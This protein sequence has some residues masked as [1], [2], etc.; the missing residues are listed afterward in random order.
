MAATIATGSI[1]ELFRRDC[2]GG[3][4]DCDYCNEA[5]FTISIHLTSVISDQKDKCRMV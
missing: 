5:M 2:P 1:P 4:A 3:G